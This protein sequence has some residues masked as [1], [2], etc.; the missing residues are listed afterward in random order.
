ML[1]MRGW[2]VAIVVGGLAGAG[3]L[4]GQQVRVGGQVSL[5]E[6]TDFGIG[7]RVEVDLGRALPGLNLVG[8]FDFFFPDNFSFGNR[9]S[10]DVDYWEINANGTYGF[11][12]PS[13][14]GF[15]PYF[16]GG[17]NISRVAVEGRDSGGPFDDS[18]TQGGLNLLVGAD[19]PLPGI[20]PFVELRLELK[21]DDP[22]G[23][24][25]QFIVTG[26]LLFP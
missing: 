12:F 4:Q 23:I 20:T 21:G 16:G 5:A 18:K 24:G 9:I 6:D 15:E 10:S 11:A 25:D 17:L 26:G 1:G 3:S 2:V 13:L 8:S 22:V 19:F 7:P 14:P